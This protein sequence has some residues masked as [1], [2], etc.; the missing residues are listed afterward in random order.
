[1]D[2]YYLSPQLC[3]LANIKSVLKV[4][5]IFRSA[6]VGYLIKTRP[7]KNYFL[8]FIVEFVSVDNNGDANTTILS[9]TGL[10]YQMPSIP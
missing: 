6:I 10:S 9:V 1:M 3:T 7:W 5:E 2:R 4:K 8:F